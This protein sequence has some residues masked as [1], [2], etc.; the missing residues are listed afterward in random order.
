MHQ[1]TQ[2]CSFTTSTYGV[3]VKNVFSH[4]APW[5]KKTELDR[6]SKGVP[7]ISQWVPKTWER[8]N[9]LGGRLQQ[10]TTTMSE[11]VG[12][13]YVRTMSMSKGTHVINVEHW[14]QHCLTT[15][16]PDVTSLMSCANNSSCAHFGA[17]SLKL[18]ENCW[19]C[20]HLFS[21][22]RVNGFI[23]SSNYTETVTWVNIE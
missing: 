21:P 4:I 15:C 8:F 19:S 7:H 3:M 20:I 17:K 12:R 23:I 14:C 10:Q 6:N 1:Q 16:A 5:W 13:W 9:G 18:T 22:W 11:N 2:F